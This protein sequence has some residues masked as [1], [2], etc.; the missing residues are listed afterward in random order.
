MHTYKKNIFNKTL[1]YSAMVVDVFVSNTEK[2]GKLL[3]F[4]I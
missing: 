4:Y 1:E 3:I 2:E